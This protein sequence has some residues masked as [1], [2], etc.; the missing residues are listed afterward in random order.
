MVSVSTKRTGHGSVLLFMVSDL[1]APTFYIYRDRVLFTSTT[2]KSIEMPLGAG[3]SPIL[4][5]TDD[6]DEPIPIGRGN[7]G[8]IRWKDVGADAYR[9]EKW[10]G[11]QWAPAELRHAEIPPKPEF[12]TGA[13]ADDGDQYRVT[14]IVNQ[15]DGSPLTVT[16]NP[17]RNPGIP[18]TTLSWS[19]ATKVIT[20]T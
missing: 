5:V 9:V 20:V 16:A 3:Q 15:E 8:L 12:Y 18:A 13:I 1:A 2:S 7:T 17:I 11:S 14:S 4:D 6:P 19:D 10:T